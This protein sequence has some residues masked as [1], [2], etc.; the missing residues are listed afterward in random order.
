VIR[1][2][3]RPVRQVGE[4]PSSTM[5]EGSAMG[6][7]RRPN[8]G[9]VAGLPGLVSSSSGYFVQ[10]SPS[11]GE[12]NA[13]Q[14]GLFIAV[15]VAIIV[16]L[17]LVAQLVRPLFAGREQPAAPDQ[18][19]NDHEERWAQWEANNATSVSTRTG[20]SGVAAQ[21]REDTVT[22]SLPA[23]DLAPE[24]VPAREVSSNG[25]IGAT[26]FTA[27]SALLDCA[28]D[29]AMLSGFGLYSDRFFEQFAVESGLSLDEFVRRYQGQGSR[30]ARERLRVERVDNVVNLPDGR[31]SARIQYAPA[32][33]LAPERYVFVW[34][35][36]RN[37]WL[38]DDILPEG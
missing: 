29:G 18:T 35:R 24:Q 26:I 12:S 28:N 31:V 13:S 38:I 19:D 11:N 33:V 36:D 37:R 2:L 17:V 5:T 15:A 4:K 14:V 32:G 20:Q 27:V 7:F 16:G 23:V 22:G 6:R 34:S 9:A 21:S 30:P 3:V 25:P 10:R 8:L 1:S